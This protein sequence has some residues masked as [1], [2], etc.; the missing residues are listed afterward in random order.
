MPTEDGKAY[1]DDK[2]KTW[3]PLNSKQKL[4]CKKMTLIKRCVSLKKST[5]TACCVIYISNLTIP[6]V[7]PKH[8]AGATRLRFCVLC[9]TYSLHVHSVHPI[10]KVIQITCKQ[11]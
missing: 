11:A 2:G 8:N 10:L 9:L 1:I 4:F 6:T 5:F 7:S 3:Q